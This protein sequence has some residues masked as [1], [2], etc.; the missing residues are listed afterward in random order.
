MSF[1]NEKQKEES[2][3]LIYMMTLGKLLEENSS[4]AKVS[5]L[6]WLGTPNRGIPLGFIELRIDLRVVHDGSWMNM[7]LKS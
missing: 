6:G 3:T 4:L 7:M 1:L 2:L 5:Q